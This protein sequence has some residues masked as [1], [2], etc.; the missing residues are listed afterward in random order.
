VKEFPCFLSP[1]KQPKSDA[2]FLPAK[3]VLR[4]GRP[5]GGWQARKASAFAPFS[6]ADRNR[7]GPR[8]VISPSVMTHPDWRGLLGGYDEAPPS[9]EAVLKQSC[10]DR[11][12]CGAVFPAGVLSS[13]TRTSISQTVG[14]NEPTGMK[15]SSA[16]RV[17][18]RACPLIATQAQPLKCHCP[19][20]LGAAFADLSH[21]DFLAL[22]MTF[23]RRLPASF[24]ARKDQPK[25]WR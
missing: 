18:R 25:D 15:S 19:V 7:Q 11:G 20:D 1:S 3:G 10:P 6:L 9:S 5:N 24:V 8:R 14:S 22:W 2:G 13:V 16:Y 4:Q 21:E 12:P 23:P 17:R